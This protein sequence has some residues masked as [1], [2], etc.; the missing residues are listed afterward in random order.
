MSHVQITITGDEKTGKSALAASI[1]HM[2]TPFVVVKNLDGD[3]QRW[4][5]LGQMPVTTEVTIHTSTVGALP[6]LISRLKGALGLAESNDDATL[7]SWARMLKTE[8]DAFQ[9]RAGRLQGELDEERKQVELLL[10]QV[11]PPMPSTSSLDR[12]RGLVQEIKRTRRQPLPVDEQARIAAY[13]HDA[14]QE[15]VNTALAKA[16]TVTLTELGRIKP[17]T[18]VD[19]LRQTEGEA[20]L[21]DAK[22]GNLKLD[23]SYLASLPPIEERRRSRE[24]KDMAQRLFLRTWSEMPNR[25]NLSVDCI[26]ML[27]DEAQRAATIYLGA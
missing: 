17:S 10:G 14:T 19:E 2:L 16:R 4:R 8:R 5:H 25:Y 13:V 23:P 20:P 15:A 26:R 21:G 24:V 11:Q 27:R 9:L 6:E 12:L 3:A 22:G 18:T 1:H 7:I